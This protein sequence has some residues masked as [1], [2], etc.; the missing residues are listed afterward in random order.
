MPLLFTNFHWWQDGSKRNMRVSDEGL[1]T[2]I[3]P[4]EPF[5]MK[6]DVLVVPLDDRG[7]AAPARIGR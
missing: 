1:V 5:G 7:R 2:Y 4:D 3:G 6:I